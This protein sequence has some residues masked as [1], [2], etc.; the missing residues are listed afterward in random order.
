M[1][2]HWHRNIIFA[3]NTECCQYNQ[4]NFLK[5]PH[6]ACLWGW[7]IGWLL[8]NGRL[9]STFCCYHHSAIC[10]MVIIGPHY[11]GTWFYIKLTMILYHDWY[12]LVISNKL[13]SKFCKEERWD[14]VWKKTSITTCIHCS[15]FMH[16]W[17]AISCPPRYPHLQWDNNYPMLVK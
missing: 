1:C 5:N 6:I 9:K 17:F 12:I 16:A 11:N 2:Y 13:E 3:W 15:W 10:N 8:S 7:G 4:V 14:T